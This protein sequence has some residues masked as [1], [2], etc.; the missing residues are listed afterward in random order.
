[1]TPS[2]HLRPTA[3]LLGNRHDDSFT[4]ATYCQCVTHFT[5]ELSFMPEDDKD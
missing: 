5:E 1:M 4:K 2:G 3:L